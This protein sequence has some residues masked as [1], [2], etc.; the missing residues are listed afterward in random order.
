MR[1]L[2]A[3]TALLA[4]TLF[5]TAGAGAAAVPA[6]I[7][8][9]ANKKSGALRLLSR[10]KCSKKKEKALSLGVTGPAGAT[11]TAGAGGA[12]G[13]PG[14]Q[15][16]Q[17]AAGTPGADGPQGPQGIQGATGTPDPSNFFTKSQSDLRFLPL[18]GTAVNADA[19]ANIPASTYVLG[20]YGQFGGQNPGFQGLA[21]G[22][23]SLAAGA[24]FTTLVLD[25]IGGSIEVSCGNPA[26]TTIRYKNTTS[27][28]LDVFLDD[29]SANP[30]Y[31]SLTQSQSITS[32]TLT[33]IDQPERLIIQAGRGSTT[34]TTG[35]VTTAVITAINRPGSATCV[36]QGQL[37]DQ[38]N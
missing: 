25:S 17:G 27:L 4:V 11:G 7:K 16:G 21:F 29:G 15:G 32:G 19:L 6:S 23:V 36:I 24:G 18:A 31:Q 10:G 20:G 38:F 5:A 22:R 34:F 12:P 8:A 28:A 1:S 9:C 3:L 33:G 37:T 35:A 30:V 13:A 2:T 26:A 14:L